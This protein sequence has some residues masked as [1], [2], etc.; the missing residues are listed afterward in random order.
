LTKR[1]TYSVSLKDP[2]AGIK[3][4][5]GQPIDFHPLPPQVAL[6]TAQ[7]KPSKQPLIVA[8]QK[9]EK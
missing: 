5:E 8:T 6:E 4:P 9:K 2:D 7:N 3:K 1:G